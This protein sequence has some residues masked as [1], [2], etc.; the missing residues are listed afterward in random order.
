MSDKTT[1]ETWVSQR[2]MEL[3]KLGYTSADADRIARR[4]VTEDDSEDDAEDKVS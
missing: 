3:L 2:I 1:D 4:E